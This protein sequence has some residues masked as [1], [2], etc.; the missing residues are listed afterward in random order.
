MIDPCRLQH[1][2][3]KRIEPD[4]K[5]R[6][7]EYTGTDKDQQFV[8]HLWNTLLSI[9]LQ[10]FHDLFHTADRDTPYD[11]QHDCDNRDDV[12]DRKTAEHIK[13]D[14]QSRH[15]KHDHTQLSNPSPAVV[16]GR[17][18]RHFTIFLVIE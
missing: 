18:F 5:E 2:D 13:Y 1:V 14:D 17:R 6:R 15:E 8:T 3:Q 16:H 12:D 4:D 10:T 7:S 9:A 11:K